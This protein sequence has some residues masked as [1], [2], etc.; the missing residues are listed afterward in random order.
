MKKTKSSERARAAAIVAAL[1]EYFPAAECALNYEG[2]PW[3]LLVLG[4]L[5]AQCTDKRVN[6]VAVPLFE[7]YPDAAAMAD[8]DPAELEE[9]IRPCGLFRTKA[10][11]LIDSSRMIIE[12]F[13]GEVPSDMDDLLL[14]PGVG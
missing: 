11:N 10:Q 14:L 13:G 6:I 2:D 8:A 7:R 12:R 9:I 3:R 5:S 4:R 1:E